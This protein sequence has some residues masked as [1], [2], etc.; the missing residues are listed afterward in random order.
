MANSW[1]KLWHDMPNDP[2]W[3]TISKISGQP[4]AVV[5]AIYLQL[6]VSASLNEERDVTDVTGVTLHS[7]TVTNEDIA[8]ALDVTESNV[9]SV[10]EAMQGRVLEGKILTGWNKRQYGS[11]HANSELKPPMTGA[12]RVAKHR[13]KKKLKEKNPS[14]VT[15]SNVTQR[16]SNGVTA[17]RKDKRRR[18]NIKPTPPNPPRGS[19]GER[20]DFRTVELPDWLTPELWECWGEYCVELQRPI[21]THRGALACISQLEKFR[22]EGYSPES[23]IRH[24]MS[25]DWKAL[26]VKNIQRAGGLRGEFIDLEGAFF[27]IIAQGKKP[28]NEAEKR[29]REKYSQAGLRKAG[30]TA[31]R[32]A[33]RGYLTQAYR[34]TGEKPI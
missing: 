20:F 21:K 8:S 31:C 1:L 32:A 14:D 30:E 9:A 7:V 3:R 2:K 18:E 5:Q 12:E 27:R 25:N 19:G 28:Q 16:Y 6:L 4:I 26:S 13:E 22:T 11:I 17:L 33:W 29:A 10:T 15:L 24:T 23:V 34:E